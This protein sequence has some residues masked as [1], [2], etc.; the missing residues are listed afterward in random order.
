MRAKVENKHHVLDAEV[1]SLLYDCPPEELWAIRPE[2]EDARG[3]DLWEVIGT[4]DS[5]RVLFVVG[6]MGNDGVFRLISARSLMEP[7]GRDQHKILGYRE[8]VRVRCVDQTEE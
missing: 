5:G 3:V 2:G 1:D 7:E 8:I 4:T 6:R